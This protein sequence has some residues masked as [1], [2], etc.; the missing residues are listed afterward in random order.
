M[1]RPQGIWEDQ[2][3]REL[4]VTAVA[5]VQINETQATSISHVL[6]D[7]ASIELRTSTIVQ[8][9]VGALYTEK[10][11]IE[12]F[13]VMGARGPEGPPGPQ[14]ESGIHVGTEPPENPTQ[15]QL[16]LKI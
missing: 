11:I 4:T 16:W 2:G 3:L 9:Q 14:G 12:Q 15:D 6:P 7:N 1:A 5:P 10:I 8:P 13:G